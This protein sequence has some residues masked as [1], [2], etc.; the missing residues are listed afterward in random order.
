MS[1]PLGGAI[2]LQHPA[3]NKENAFPYPENAHT[4]W[5]NSGRAALQ[6]L[7]QTRPTPPRTVWLPRFICNT[8]TQ[9]IAGLRLR[10]KFYEI[11]EQLCPILP[12]EL[13][14]D[15]ALVVVNYFGLTPQAVEA[16]AQV[17]PCS[18]IMDAS[19]AFY[20][21]APDGVATFYSPRKF[22]GLADGG[23]ATAPYEL[24]INLPDNPQSDRLSELLMQN[25]SPEAVQQAEDALDAPPLRM[26]STTRK[27]MQ[28]T[29]WAHAAH[30]RL[31]NYRILHRALAEI[32]RLALPDTPAHAPM[33]YPLVCGIPGLRDNL[34]DQ[35]V[36]LPL[37]WP[38]VI[39]T[40]D[41]WQTENRMARTLLPLPLDQRY[42]EA[43]M[44]KLL[45]MILN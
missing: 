26:G 44:Q 31:S 2:P 21:P 32:N 37:Y 24:N 3:N 9:A 15:D 41:A 42:N 34:I 19:T 28:A 7:L 35:G 1:T 25:A 17:A 14:E 45:R 16:A 40:T 38:E 30:R 36:R 13:K 27:L 39:A 4:L 23:I 18:V 20:S 11:D 8:V 5:V 33:C 29:D 6:C 22:T 12:N 43:D 10:T